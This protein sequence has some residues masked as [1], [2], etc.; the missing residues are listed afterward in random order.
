[1]GVDEWRESRS[2]GSRRR[3]RGMINGKVA[4]NFK[5]KRMFFAFNPTLSQTS[6]STHQQTKGKRKGRRTHLI[7]KKE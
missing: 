1:V 6:S 3:L 2:V 7:T 5:D 4:E